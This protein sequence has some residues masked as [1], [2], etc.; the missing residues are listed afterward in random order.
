MTRSDQEPEP[1]RFRYVGADQTIE[2]RAR[3]ADVLA[4]APIS[5]AKGAQQG[6]MKRTVILK[7]GSYVATDM[8][9]GQVTRESFATLQMTF[10]P[11]GELIDR[12]V[13]R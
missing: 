13:T 11:T 10:T 3:S 4:S 9:T 1:Y 2:A 8:K 7:S 6:S 5:T 12:V